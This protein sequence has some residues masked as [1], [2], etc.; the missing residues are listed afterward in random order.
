M[1]NTKAHGWAVAAIH[2][3]VLLGV[4]GRREQRSEWWGMGR[5]FRGEEGVLTIVEEAL[6]C[7][8]EEFSSV[9]LP[10]H[11]LQPYYPRTSEPPPYSEV[12][13][14]RAS[15]PPLHSKVWNVL[16]ANRHNLGFSFTVHI[17]LKYQLKQAT[18]QQRR[19]NNNSQITTLSKKRATAQRA[20]PAEASHR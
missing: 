8:C 15:L 14:D 3:V 19:V 9:V 16:S 12:Q 1:T 17:R 18:S 5:L 13:S 20:Y 10:P 2:H 4:G 6:R 7:F 11:P